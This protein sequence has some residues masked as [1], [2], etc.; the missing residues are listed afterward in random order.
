M[1]RVVG[2]LH[3]KLLGLLLETCLSSPVFSTSFC[4]ILVGEREV[5]AHGMEGVG[6]APGMG[7]TGSVKP[8]VH[9]LYVCKVV[10]V[11]LQLNCLS[12]FIAHSEM[13]TWKTAWKDSLY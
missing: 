1:V 7:H 11:I 5:K 12:T 13:L 8:L 3:T 6:R 4:L 9:Q 2:N 10:T